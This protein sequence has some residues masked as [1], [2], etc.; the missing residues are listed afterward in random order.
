MSDNPFAE[1]GDE[2]KT[3]V[4]RPRPGGQRSSPPPQ[5]ARPYAPPREPEAELAPM[6]LSGEGAT[7][8]DFGLNPLVGAAAPLLQL[9]ARLNTTYSQPNALAL[10]DRAQSQLRAYDQAA[11]EAGIPSDQTDKGRFAL[12]ATLDDM[13]QDTPWGADGGWADHPLVLGVRDVLVSTAGVQSAIG[14]FRLLDEVKKNPGTELHVLELMYL[15][16]ALGFQGRYRASRQGPAEL[17]RIREDLYTI[18]VRQRGQV[19]SELSPHWKGLNIPYR[20]ARAS[21]PTWVVFVAVLGIL[22]V[23]FA[24]FS[25]GLSIA[26]DATLD[27]Q[28]AAPLDHMPKIVRVAPPRPAVPLPPPPPTPPAPPPGP[29]PLYVFLKPEIDQKLVSVVGTKCVPIV[30]ILNKGMFQSGAA[31]VSPQFTRLLERIGEALKAEK[32]PVQVIGYTDNQPIHTI[33]FPSNFELSK[34]RA[35]AALT[36]I[37]K[38]LGDPPRVKSEGRAAA[39][40]IGSNETAEGRDQNRRIEVVLRREGC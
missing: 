12:C 15:C 33:A 19:A 25:A 22:G 8:I 18:I 32:G 40:P 31:T 4:S 30:R 13:A 29:D 2:D 37:V 34:A 38:S 17:A 28:L 10:R 21:L 35:D 27:R 16:L 26:S 5:A 9:I 11:R 3:L 7:T 24:V 14:F 39:D 20:P 6:A 1:D 23:L 36:I